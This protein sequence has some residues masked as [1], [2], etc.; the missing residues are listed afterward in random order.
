MRLDPLG[1]ELHTDSHELHVDAEA[2]TWA[3]N[4]YLLEFPHNLF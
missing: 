4:L 3:L 1:L 2:G